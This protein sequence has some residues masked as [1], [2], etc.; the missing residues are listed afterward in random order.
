MALPDDP[1]RIGTAIGGFILLVA[2]VVKRVFSGRRS[3]KATLSDVVGELRGL[4]QDNQRLLEFTTSISIA[5]SPL[6]ALVVRR[7]S[8]TISE[9]N[10]A[11]HELFGCHPGQLVGQSV[12]SLIVPEDRGRHRHYV[13]D[14]W[15]APTTRPMAMGRTLRALRYDQQQ[16]RVRIALMPDTVFAI[17]RIDPVPDEQEAA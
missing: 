11:A 6:P 5:L 15:L 16:I 12:E 17:V 14:F 3:S 10:A 1:A 9:A 4:R 8:M 13:E 7:E 2:G